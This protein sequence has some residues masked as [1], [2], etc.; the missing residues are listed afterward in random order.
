MSGETE[1]TDQEFAE[2]NFDV[3]EKQ[4]TQMKP[5]EFNE[6]VTRVNTHVE[7]RREQ[8]VNKFARMGD[9]EFREHVRK[10]FGFTP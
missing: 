4:L 10:N 1:N 9:G 5:D 7:K 3:V 8:N 2:L 6:L